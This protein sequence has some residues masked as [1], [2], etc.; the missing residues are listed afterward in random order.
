MELSLHLNFQLRRSLGGYT[1]GTTTGFCV[2]TT[3]ALAPCLLVFLSHRISAS[4]Q[5]PIIAH[6]PGVFQGIKCIRK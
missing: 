2:M 4:V 3:E 6:H 1:M 5:M